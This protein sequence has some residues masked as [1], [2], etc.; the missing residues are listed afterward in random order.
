MFYSASDNNVNTVNLALNVTTF[1]TNIE[2]WK[3]N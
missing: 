3:E 1:S 2:E